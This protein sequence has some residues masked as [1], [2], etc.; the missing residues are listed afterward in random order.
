M[1][2]QLC[3]VIDTLRYHQKAMARTDHL[4][5]VRSCLLLYCILATC[6]IYIGNENHEAIKQERAPVQ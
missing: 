2:A 6:K 3:P 4:N 1:G 5:L